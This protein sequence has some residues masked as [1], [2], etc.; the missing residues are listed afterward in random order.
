MSTLI[1][2]DYGEGL[3]RFPG[4]FGGLIDDYERRLPHYLSDL[5]M[6]WSRKTLSAALMMF[7][8]TF[9]STVALGAAIERHTHHSIGTSEYLLMNGIA[10]IVYSIVGCQPMLILRP[11]GPITLILSQLFTLS[12]ACEVDFFALV[13]WSGIGIGLW[14]FAITAIEFSRHVAMLSC[15]A[16][17]VFAVFVSS[18]YVVDGVSGTIERFNTPFASKAVFAFIITVFLIAVAASFSALRYTKSLFPK[19]VRYLLADYALGIATAAATILSYSYGTAVDVERIEIAN[20]NKWFEF[21]SAKPTL[22]GRDWMVPVMSSHNAFFAALLGLAVSLPITVF[23]YFDQNLSSLLCQ[24]KEVGLTKGSYYHSSFGLMGVFNL[25]GPL[26]GLPFVTGSLPHSPQ[27]VKALTHDMKTSGKPLVSENRVAPF[28]MYSGILLSYLA[29]S[30]IIETIPVAA[31][32]AVLIFVGIEGIIDTRLWQRIS[33]LVTPDSEMSPDIQFPNAAR[34]FT[35]LQLAVLA[36][37]WGLNMTPFGLAFPV[38]IACLVPIRAYV[39]PALFTNFELAILDGEGI[40]LADEVKKEADVEE[41]DHDHLHVGWSGAVTP[42]TPHST[43]LNSDANYYP[44][45]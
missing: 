2:D 5:T 45:E 11:T 41:I 15:F 9:C 19:T 17:D 30:G 18:I 37:G 20:T 21:I 24:T 8:A 16:H 29:F 10:G 44:S 35:L 42:L 22:W 33:V 26:F 31:T 7:L 34:K 27:M 1:K 40:Q 28:L 23:F 25:I 3:K 36:A 13:A 14:M 43:K 38:V 39:L 32:D 6:A 4:Y 12:I